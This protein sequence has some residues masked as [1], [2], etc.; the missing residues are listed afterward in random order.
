VVCFVPLKRLNTISI[1]YRCFLSKVHIN[2]NSAPDSLLLNPGKKKRGTRFGRTCGD[3][4]N[5]PGSSRTNGCNMIN[6]IAARQPQRP[7]LSLSVAREG[8]RCKCRIN[9]VRTIA[10]NKAKRTELKTQQKTER[11]RLIMC[12]QS[13]QMLQLLGA[14]STCKLRSLS[15]RQ[16]R[17][18][19]QLSGTF[20]LPWSTRW[21]KIVCRFLDESSSGSE[22]DSVVGPFKIARGHCN[23][24]R[25]A[26]GLVD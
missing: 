24:Q 1:L 21:S 18:Y 10:T 13:I 17:T 2:H 4:A 3:H 26:A 12:G 16:R 9:G 8:K 20:D 15:R 14:V 22:E 23:S 7:P 6:H 5:W 19:H 11:T 25:P